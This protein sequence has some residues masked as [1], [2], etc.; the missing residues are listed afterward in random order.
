MQLP[1]AVSSQR[2][3]ATKAFAVLSLSGV[4]ALTACGGGDSSEDL[5]KSTSTIAG[6]GVTTVPPGQ[7]VVTPTTTVR[8]DGLSGDVDP[9]SITADVDSQGANGGSVKAAG[10][11]T[12]TGGRANGLP[13]VTIK[14]P[15]DKSA[16]GVLT[17]LE[18]ADLIF[19]ELVE[20]GVTRFAAVFNSTLPDHVQPVRSVRGPDPDLALSVGGVFAYSG[21]AGPFVERINSVPIVAVDES[22]GGSALYRVAGKAPYNLA[23]SAEALAGMSDEAARSPFRF[24]SAALKGGE[25]ANNV[26]VKVSNAQTSNFRY[27]AAAGAYRRYNGSTPEVSGGVQLAFE[28]VV[29]IGVATGPTGVI[30]T[31]GSESPQ[32]YTVG[33]GTAWLFRDGK[34]FVGRWSRAHETA[35][36][37]II[38]DDGSAYTLTPGRSN[39]VLLPVSGI[40]AG[41]K[42]GWN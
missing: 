40:Y 9:S 28:N 13:A 30:D 32:S 14:V 26:S 34:V 2:R 7:Q 19:E 41:G 20:G 10:Q 5:S 35:P 1:Q 42:I 12:L 38:A 37:E 8:A 11:G 31:A 21:G 16:R 27:D 22:S 23:A 18:D 4:L 3:R 36:W 25:V 33:S 6:A 24:S 39:V 15:N 17:G 29:V